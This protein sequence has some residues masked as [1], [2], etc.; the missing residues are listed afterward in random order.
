VVERIE[1]KGYMRKEANMNSFIPIVV[2]GV[3]LFLF[4]FL[5]VFGLALFIIIK[6]FKNVTK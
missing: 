4:I 1:R 3:V 2:I 5:I 6:T